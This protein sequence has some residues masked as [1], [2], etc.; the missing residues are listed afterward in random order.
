MKSDSLIKRF[1]QSG[2][3]F[4][5]GSTLTADAVI[6]ATGYGDA[7]A[8]VRNICGAGIASRLK[9]LWG[10]DEEGEVP[11]LWRPSGVR[12]LWVHMGTHPPRSG[13]AACTDCTRH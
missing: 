3:E 9:P 12:G 13:A 8:P 6:C 7:A 1:T 2:I 4:E 11:G 10:L 5:D